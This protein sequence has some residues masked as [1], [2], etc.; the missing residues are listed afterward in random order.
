MVGVEPKLKPGSP[1]PVMLELRES[2]G[3]NEQQ[4]ATPATATTVVMVVLR[5]AGDW[6]EVR[7]VRP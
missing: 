5:V 1:D 6:K 4:Q 7:T 2:E 3:G